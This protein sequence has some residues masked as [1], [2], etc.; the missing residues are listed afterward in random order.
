MM[1]HPAGNRN[2]DPLLEV[3]KKHVDTST[4]SNLLEIS[5][6]PGLHICY[7]AKH[8]PN[9]TFQPSE[10]TTNFFDS[11]N[12]YREHFVTKN[13]N[14]PIFIDIS[15]SLNDW[16]GKFDDKHLKD[17]KSFFDYIVSIN[18][19]HITP[20]ECCEGLFINSAKLL[21]P[22]GLLFT[23]GTFMENGILT[24]LSNLLFDQRLKLNDPS[25]GVRDISELEQFAKI[26]SMSLCASYDMPTDSKCLVWIKNQ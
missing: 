18:M 24:P 16:T 4:E 20:I 9:T 12:A 5:S 10:Y 1:D 26:N 15:E 11:I 3:L 14:K 13:V 23:Y 7:F 25:W 17:C 19:I 8:F 2:K 6:G 21:K 22:G